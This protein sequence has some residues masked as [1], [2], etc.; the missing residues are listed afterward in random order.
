MNFL[1]QEKLGFKPK[2]FRVCEFHTI[3]E[4]EYFCN[5]KSMKHFPLLNSCP[6]CSRFGIKCSLK[7]QVNRRVSMV[8]GSNRL[9]HPWDILMPCQSALDGILVLLLIQLPVNAHTLGRQKLKPQAL[10]YLTHTGDP[11]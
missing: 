1:P 2:H 8:L 9:S 7:I 10:G 5:L 6:L 11:K 4:I 3:R